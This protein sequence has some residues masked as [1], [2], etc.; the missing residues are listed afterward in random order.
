MSR[1]KE[2][3]PGRGGPD[4]APPA[5]G[6]VPEPAAGAPAGVPPAVP[7]SGASPAPDP[8]AEQAATI[9][10]LQDQLLRL[11]ADFDNFRKRTLREKTELY[12]SAASELML[13]LLPVLDHLQLG[14]Q[15]AANHQADQSFLDGLRLIFDQLMGVL[16]KFGLLPMEVEGQPFDPARC[17]AI[18]CLPSDQVPEGVVL[19]QTRRGYLLRNK[20]LRPAQVV[21]SGGPPG[22]RQAP[23]EN[24]TNRAMHPTRENEP[25][26]LDK[27]PPRL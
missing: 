8:L 4:K 5:A 1:N 10:A 22:R 16:T 25:S 18:S 14:L 2:K 20:L 3:H 23:D 9:A 17:E 19:K 11:R 26:P 27:E 13:E 15:A 21:V 12:E 7:A 24:K 6:P